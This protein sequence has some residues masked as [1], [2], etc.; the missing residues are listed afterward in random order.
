MSDRRRALSAALIA[1]LRAGLAELDPARLVRDALP[2]LP[3]KR[4]RVRIVAAGKAAARM[5]AGAID[6]WGSRIDDALVITVDSSAPPPSSAGRSSSEQRTDLSLVAVAQVSRVDVLHA[7]HPIPDSR[8]ALAAEEA[9]RRAGDLGQDDLLLALISGGASSLL[10]LPPAGVSLA[11]KQTI[12][13]RLLESGAPIGDVNLVRRHVS[14]IKGG[15]LAAQA[16]PARVLTLIVSDV[17][18]GAPHDIGSGPTVFDPTTVSDAVAVLRRWAL[19]LASPALLGALTESLKPAVTHAE[20]AATPPV[21][22]LR[23]RILADPDALARA[24]A[25]SLNQS[26]PFRARVLPPEQGDALDMVRRRIDL[27]RHLSPGEAVVIPCEPTLAL[28]KPRG[29]GGR[30]GFIA[31]ASMRDLPDGVLLLC[32]ATDGVDGSSG[33]AGAVVARSDTSSLEDAAIDAA[34]TA[35]DDARIHQILGTHIEGGPTGHN[36]TDLHILARA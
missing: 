16:A 17:I 4:S 25:S 29:R 12:V 28:P 35:F 31:L 9:L 27:A 11:D 21:P 18:G 32:A 19:D 3:P 20:G 30:A 10:A 24:V 36:L 14:R 22:R 6:R 15:R 5:T 26:G 1:A 13:A 8:S 34:L 7:A 2:P 33:A 23:A